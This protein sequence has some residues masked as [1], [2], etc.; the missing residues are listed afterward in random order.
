M[1]LQCYAG[2]KLPLDS[3]CR[4]EFIFKLKILEHLRIKDN[5]RLLPP[6]SNDMDH[7]CNGTTK[8]IFHVSSLLYH[9]PSLIITKFYKIPFNLDIFCPPAAVVQSAKEDTRLPSFLFNFTHYRG[10][11]IKMKPIKTVFFILLIL[12]NSLFAQ[13]FTAK[14]LGIEQGLS[15]NSI[16]SIYQDYNGL[17]GL[18]HTM[19]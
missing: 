16:L 19:G 5:L 12:N 10:R 13:N 15:N 11:M 3:S 8:G 7:I 9:W 4:P 2:L 18:A 17:C 1:N 6:P 14:Y